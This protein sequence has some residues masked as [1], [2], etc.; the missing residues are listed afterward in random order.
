MQLACII[1]RQSCL[2]G[3]FGAP[4][5][6]A[7]SMY[8]RSAWDHPHRMSVAFLLAVFAVVEASLS[9]TLLLRCNSRP[10]AA[11]EDNWHATLKQLPRSP[12]PDMEEV[13]CIRSVSTEEHARPKGASH[14][15]CKVCMGVTEEVVCS[16]CLVALSD[17]E[18]AG[19]LP[20]K[21]VFHKSCIMKWMDTGHGCPMRCSARQQGS[22]EAERADLWVADL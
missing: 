5:Y 8:V 12:L 17:G 2:M 19:R 3:I 21:H 4:L 9:C 7:E 11:A 16:I 13:R 22:S 18:V 6:F 15:P 20:C 14:S 1:S 10:R